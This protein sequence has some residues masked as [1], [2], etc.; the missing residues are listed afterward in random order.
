MTKVAAMTDE[1]KAELLLGWAQKLASELDGKVDKVGG[2][3]IDVLLGED[4][5]GFTIAFSDYRA[6]RIEVR[7]IWPKKEDGSR[8]WP[9]V[10][11]QSTFAVDRPASAVAKQIQRDFLPKYEEIWAEQKAQADSWNEH[12]RQVKANRDRV[13]AALVDAYTPRWGSTDVVYGRSGMGEWRIGANSVEIMRLSIR[14]D[15]IEE[16]AEFLKGKVSR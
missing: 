11:P 12:S 7:G 16:V 14:A 13:L 3:W 10:R 2:Y 9:D 8:Y 1:Q 5:R 6:Q 4:G 15:A